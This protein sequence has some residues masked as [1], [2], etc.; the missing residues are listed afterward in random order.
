MS[1]NSGCTIRPPKPHKIESVRDE[2]R[3]AFFGTSLDD[4]EK[5]GMF[6][7]AECCNMPETFSLI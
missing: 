4:S 2:I 3:I 7:Q 5:G 6:L 1:D